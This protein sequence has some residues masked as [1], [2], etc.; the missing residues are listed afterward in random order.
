MILSTRILSYD[1]D[2]NEP[3]N[4][5]S[6]LA[7]SDIVE[8]PN[9]SPSADDTEYRAQQNKEPSVIEPAPFVPLPRI[10]SKNNIKSKLYDNT[11]KRNRSNPNS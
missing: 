8:Y 11:E 3:F 2:F 1:S 4:P 10:P 7:N 5:S 6:T 9:L